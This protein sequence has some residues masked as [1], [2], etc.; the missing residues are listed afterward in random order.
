M[1]TCNMK[2]I[3]KETNDGSTCYNSIVTATVVY[4]SIKIFKYLMQYDKFPNIDLSCVDGRQQDTALILACW[5]RKTKIVSLLLNH[6]NMTKKIINMIDTQG[7]TAFFYA[8]SR[9]ATD[10]VKIMIN[11][12]RV[13]M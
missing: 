6:P 10:I 13:D 8:Y 7:G 11:D 4:Q 5:H 3:M 9:N 1:L 12:E 2:D